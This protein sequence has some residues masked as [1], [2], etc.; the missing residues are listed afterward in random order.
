MDGRM[1]GWMDRCCVICNAQKN[2]RTTDDG[3]TTDATRR[4]TTRRRMTD[5]GDAEVFDIRAN[6]SRN[7][8]ER[9]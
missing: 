4:D 2:A 8:P 6:A 5:D 9:G 1:D 3:R 7:A